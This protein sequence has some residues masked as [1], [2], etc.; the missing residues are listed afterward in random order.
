MRSFRKIPW[1]SGDACPPEILENWPPCVSNMSIQAMSL[2][3]RLNTGIVTAS[4]HAEPSELL[5]PTSR[6][7]ETHFG[8]A[9]L[10]PLQRRYRKPCGMPT[11]LCQC[12]AWGERD[13][14][15]VQWGVQMRLSVELAHCK[16]SRT[17][18]AWN[19][20][21]TKKKRKRKSS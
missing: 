21:L 13:G 15:V 7:V 8:K 6:P 4:K 20:Q 11:S 3:V 2:H 10:G 12:V 19:A 16:A 14:V 1:T 5:I 17:F 18:V 9:R